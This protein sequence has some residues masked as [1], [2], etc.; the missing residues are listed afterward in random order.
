MEEDE[1]IDS[2]FIVADKYG[3]ESLKNWCC[4]TMSKKPSIEKAIRFLV[5]AHLFSAKKLEENR[6]CFI[7][8]NKSVFWK[9]PEFKQL[10]ENYFK[11]FFD[12]TSRIG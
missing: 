12:I 11:L 6:I 4:L 5:L 3:D 10:G 9:R 7:V 8:Q 2:L 1:T